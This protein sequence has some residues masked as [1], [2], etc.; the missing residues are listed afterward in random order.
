MKSAEIRSLSI[1]DLNTLLKENQTNL[2]KMKLNHAVT[3]I[4]NPNEFSKIRK[5]IARLLTELN[6][7][8]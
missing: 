5:T 8:G 1:E 7:R 2:V 4:E 6:K 3:P